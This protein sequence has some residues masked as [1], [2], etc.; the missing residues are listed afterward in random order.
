M[1]EINT[2]NQAKPQAPA[3][4]FLPLLAS[5]PHI[6]SPVNSAALMRN[7]L[8]A[9]AP[10]SI[11]G[12][13]IFGLP[14]LLNIIVSASAAI[15]AEALFRLLTGQ[16]AR[17]G[18]LSAGVTGLLLALVIPPA[19]PLWMTA[20][21]AIFAVIV[22]KE[23]FGGLGA[24]VFNPALVGRAF[25]LMSFPAAL[26]VWHQPQ[27]S[28]VLRLTAGMS[29]AGLVDGVSGVTPLGII[30]S[31][32]GIGAVGKFFSA[33]GLS[34]SDSYWP[35]I[36]T[37]FLGFRAGCIGESSILLILAAF[38]FLLA[39][40]T[41]DWRAPVSMTAAAFLCSLALGM[42]PLFAVLSGGLLFGAVFMATDYVSTPLT[43]KGKILFGIGAGIISVL[44]RKWGTYPEGV[45]Y[46]I[47]IMNGVT[48]FLNKLLP[49]KYG[50]VPKKKPAPPSG[51][52]SPGEAAK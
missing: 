48:P 35:T 17:A 29:G 23:F 16:Q 1:E 14:A 15:A 21:G 32:A 2:A 10:V 19:T 34:P 40:K 30:K 39:T 25:L 12:I 3:G 31:G 6:A 47:L 9:L 37:L 11:Y 13:A 20:L 8:V 44:I 52:A 18:D 38:V 45:S 43:A 42:D 27:R 5:S 7:M 4:Q 46:S 41:I 36:K 26:T 50:F 24:N 33:A 51:A 22:A 28:F 49:R